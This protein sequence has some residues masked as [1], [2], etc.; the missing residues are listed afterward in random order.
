MAESEPDAIVEPAPELDVEPAD[1]VEAPVGNVLAQLE[2]FFAR[3]GPFP[4]P[5]DVD[6]GQRGD[7]P[8]RL[9][10]HGLQR[11]APGALH[12]HRRARL[13]NPAP[14]GVVRACRSRVTQRDRGAPLMLR[15]T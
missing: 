13:A 6:A 5:N 12:R 1:P 7:L 14:L 4:V 9:L 8:W 10:R 11:R 3:L 2:Q 15:T